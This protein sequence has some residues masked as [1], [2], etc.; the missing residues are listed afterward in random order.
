VQQGGV[1]EGVG[2]VDH[3]DEPKAV[4][5]VHDTGDGDGGYLKAS[6]EAPDDKNEGGGSDAEEEDEEYDDYDEYEDAY[7]DGD[8]YYAY[9]GE[10]ASRARSQAHLYRGRSVSDAP[11]ALFATELSIFP[12]TEHS[13]DRSATEDDAPILS[14]RSH[15]DAATAD[16]VGGDIGTSG[17][18]LATTATTGVVKQLAEG[19]SISSFIKSPR[20]HAPTLERRVSCSS[21]DFMDRGITAYVCRL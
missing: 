9:Y 15:G 3:P 2:H 5:I 10:K 17:G 1:D 8:G 18:N 7:D 21:S 20:T 16:S 19:G 6:K 14:A 11:M 4:A 13:R 12:P